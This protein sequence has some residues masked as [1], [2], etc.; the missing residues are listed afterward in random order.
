MKSRQSLKA[1]PFSDETASCFFKTRKSEGE[2][3]V[4]I[5]INMGSVD[6]WFGP[7]LDEAWTLPDVEKTH[8]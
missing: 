5:D 7:L 1:F 8:F 4:K 2:Q 3:P 6:V